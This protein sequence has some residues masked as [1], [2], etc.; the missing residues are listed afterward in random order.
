MR[1]NELLEQ[2]IGNCTNLFDPETG[3]CNLPDFVDVSDFANKDENAKEIE[4]DDF[5]KF[6]KHIPDELE[7][8]IKQYN[9]QFLYYDNN[10]FVLYIEPVFDDDNN[11]DDNTDIHYFFRKELSE[12]PISDI[13]P[14]GDPDPEIDQDN[15]DELPKAWTEPEKRDWLSDTPRAKEWRNKVVK[16]WSK[17]KNNYLIIPVF[18][19]DAYNY[20][21]L[22]KG[23]VPVIELATE[24]P[25]GYN[26]LQEIEVLDLPKE[27]LAQRSSKHADKTVVFFLGNAADQWV[28]S[29][30]WMLL[31]RLGHASRTT[32]KPEMMVNP[33]YS[34]A[35]TLMFEQLQNTFANYGIDFWLD[36]D[37][38]IDAKV[39]TGYDNSSPKQHVWSRE[40]ALYALQKIMTMRSARAGK[41]RD[42]YEALY[43]MWAQ[44]LNTGGVKFRVPETFDFG[45]QERRNKPERK[46]EQEL[47][48][49]DTELIGS[50]LEEFERIMNEEA[51]P[52]M[53]ESIAGEIL[54]M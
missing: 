45:G 8:L 37:P 39:P 48:P 11:R 19:E 24:F 50:E 44:Y 32:H 5:R 42:V 25:E 28:R 16:S 51:F 1:F 49:G 12:A 53:E 2:Y 52:P 26:F 21:I 33:A 10:L 47:M 35:I 27:G 29:S 9:H 31:H 22:E 54:I 43:E 46:N 20:E 34:H 14:M 23:I 30:G 36:R 17:T 40:W 18:G 38:N 15:A 4:E 6:V 3:G 13:Q 41:L 7:D